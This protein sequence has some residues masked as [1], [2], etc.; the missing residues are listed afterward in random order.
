MDANSK[1][2]PDIINLDPHSQI[3]NGRVLVGIIERHRLIVY[4]FPPILF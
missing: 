4:C 3:Q 1:L 2:G